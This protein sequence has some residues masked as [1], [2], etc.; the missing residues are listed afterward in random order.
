[1]K[2]AKVPLALVLSGSSGW[3]LHGCR[4]IFTQR[5]YLWVKIY[6]GRLATVSSWLGVRDAHSGIPE[7]LSTLHQLVRGGIIP[8]S[9][10]FP[11][12]LRDTLQKYSAG[13]K[14]WV[15]NRS[16]VVSFSL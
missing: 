16:R 1:M 13:K 15:T 9:Q 12:P 6:S 5:G 14:I 2:R 8:R 10:G 11:H 7:L 4:A 3:R